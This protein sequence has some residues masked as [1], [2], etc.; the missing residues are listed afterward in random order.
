MTQ[1]TPDTT[2]CD[3]LIVGMG[4][5]GKAAALMLA[6]QGHTVVM[7]ERKV[8]SYPPELA[9]FS[10]LFGVSEWISRCGVPVR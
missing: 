1:F 8:K 4:P 5:V 9:H 2:D 10:A 3:V 6:Q 7:V